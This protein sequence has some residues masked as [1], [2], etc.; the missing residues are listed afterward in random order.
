LCV[1]GILNLLQKVLSRRAGLYSRE[2]VY[3]QNMSMGTRLFIGSLSEGECWL[4]VEVG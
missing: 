2:G 3:V 4:V 1:Y